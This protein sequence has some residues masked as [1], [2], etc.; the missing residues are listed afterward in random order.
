MNEDRL[1][2]IV[3]VE[4]ITNDGGGKRVLS[5]AKKTLGPV[6]DRRGNINHGFS[7]EEIAD[8]EKLLT[9]TLDNKFWGNFKVVLSDSRKEFDMSV[10]YDRLAVGFIRKHPW[11]ADVGQSLTND[12]IYRIIDEEFEASKKAAILD[13]KKVA[14]KYLEAMDTEDA[15]AFLLLY[16]IKSSK[17]SK[18]ALMGKLEDI[19]ISDPK[20]FCKYYEDKDKDL[21]ILLRELVTNA[22]VHKNKE[23]YFWGEIHMGENEQLAIVY[24]K[25]VE[26][27]EALIGMKRELEEKKKLT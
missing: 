17:M 21:K 7:P 18:N 19:L 9:M 5:G 12:T 23:H 2:G 22:V 4:P 15:R 10:P 16:G 3:V 8:Y 20:K 27:Q 26:H 1:E 6:L 25:D 24:L 13:D 11:V 14:Y